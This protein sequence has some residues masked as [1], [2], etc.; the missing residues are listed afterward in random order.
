MAHESDGTVFR[1]S[2]PDLTVEIR[3]EE[4]FVRE[5][6]QCMGILERI[7]GTLQPQ[8]AEAAQAILNSGQVNVLPGAPAAA[9]ATEAEDARTFFERCHARAG[10]GAHFDRVLLIGYWL[11]HVNGRKQFSKADIERTY[12][13]IGL[14]LPKHLDQV[15]G[16]IRRDHGLFEQAGR[17]GRYRLTDEGIQGA[18]ELGA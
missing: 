7:A 17:V 11:E 10:K 14:D 18:K 9:V 3:G 4:E 8:Q 16:S 6:I 12:E 2:S 5:Q 1:Y 13:D 15:I